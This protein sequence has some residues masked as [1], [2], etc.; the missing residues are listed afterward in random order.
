MLFHEMRNSIFM[1]RTKEKELNAHYGQM[2]TLIH[3]G[4]TV[5]YMAENLV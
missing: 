1:T 2:F 3:L 5:P 4:V